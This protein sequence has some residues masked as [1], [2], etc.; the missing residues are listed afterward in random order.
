M[1]PLAAAPAHAGIT[2]NAC[3]ANLV[4]IGVRGTDAPAGSGSQYLPTLWSSGGYGEQVGPMRNKIAAWANNTGL[5]AFTASLNYQASLNYPT[6]H[7]EGRDRLVNV[8]NSLTYCTYRPMVVLG[9]HS[10]GADVVASA[11]GS[12]SLS[13]AA[14]DMVKAA[15]MYGD[16]NAVPGVNYLAPGS[17]SNVWG[18]LGGRTPSEESVLQG[19]AFYKW[20]WPYESNS[21]GYYSKIRSYCFTQ[22]WACT[23]NPNAGNANTWHNSYYTLTDQV[24]NWILYLTSSQV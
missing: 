2:A 21:Q 14:R 18:D 23:P 8:L 24:F 22:D 1:I 19:P 16:P 15:F 5:M 12:A 11:L 13:S 3:N 7:A 17:P 9:G 4:F 10:Q 20:G 6:S